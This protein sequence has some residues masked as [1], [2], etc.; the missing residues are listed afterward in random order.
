[1]LSICRKPRHAS[2]GRGRRARRGTALLELALVM[3]ILAAL[4]LGVLDFGRMYAEQLAVTAAAREGARAAMHD[5][6]DTNV[7]NVVTNELN[8]AVVPNSSGSSCGNAICINRDTAGGQ[9]V[10]TVNYTHSFLFGLIRN[11]NLALAASAT[12]PYTGP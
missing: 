6:S 8:G 12:M 7:R 3:P 5:T 9:V 10:V 4:L 11:G 1:M 2:A